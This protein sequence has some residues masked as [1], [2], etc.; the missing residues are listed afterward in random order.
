L[1]CSFRT[2]SSKE[3]KKEPSNNCFDQLAQPLAAVETESVSS[4][5]NE[6]VFRK[7]GSSRIQNLRASTLL[8]KSHEVRAKND[9]KE[10]ERS[11]K[12]KQAAD[13]RKEKLW[14]E[15]YAYLHNARSSILRGQD[16]VKLVQSDTPV[17]T[18]EEVLERCLQLKNE[19]M[20]S[21]M[22]DSQWLCLV[23]V[24]VSSVLYVFKDL[25]MVGVCY[26]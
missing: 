9:E 11:N 2:E 6:N 13:E 4:A 5:V 26:Q 7:V 8:Q 14:K 16:L 1:H 3:L 25:K 10:R 22:E 15:F 23:Q 21:Q 18:K 24:V 12:E 19:A 17:L 20:G